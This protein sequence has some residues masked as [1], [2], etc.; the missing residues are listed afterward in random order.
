MLNLGSAVT[1]ASESNSRGRH[2]QPIRRIFHRPRGKTYR[3]ANC[4]GIEVLADHAKCV[5]V[6]HNSLNRAASLKPVIST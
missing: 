3:I 4:R 5:S 6:D 2:I 1:R